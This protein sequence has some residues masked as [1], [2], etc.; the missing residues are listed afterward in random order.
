VLTRA[1]KLAV[2]SDPRG[3]ERLETLGA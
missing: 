2:L 1:E 3:F